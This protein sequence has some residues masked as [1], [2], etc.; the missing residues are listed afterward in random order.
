MQTSRQRKLPLQRRGD[1]VDGRGAP[2]F[3]TIA[4]ACEMLIGERMA[5]D[6]FVLLSRNALAAVHGGDDKAPAQPAPNPKCWTW[7]P[8]YRNGRIVGA[9]KVPC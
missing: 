4:V 7:V 5:A 8:I 6:T 2:K 1:K 9:N 3:G